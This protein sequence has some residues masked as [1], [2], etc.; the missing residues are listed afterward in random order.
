VNPYEHY[1]V[2]KPH[3]ITISYDDLKTWEKYEKLGMQ[4]FQRAAFVLVAGGLGERLG[5]EGIKVSIPK[6][7]LT[8][9][10][11]LQYYCEYIHAF[12]TKFCEGNSI[13]LVIMTSEDTHAK[14]LALLETNKYFGLRPEQV[15]ILNQEKVP[16]MVDNEGRFGVVADRLE[17]ETKPHGHGD[18]HTLLHMHGTAEKWLAEGRKWI[19]I[20]Q[21]TNPFAL[22]S[23][24]LLL[25]ISAERNFDFNSL[26][27]PRKPGEA[28]GA[29]TTLVHR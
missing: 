14:T 5:Y 11:F 22:R 17:I 2:G 29:I 8:T 23:F 15:T 4:E 26:A 1:E 3:G 27:V 24:A 10:C 7:L 6:E 19:I 25:G 18:V 20:F 9:K 21:D 12:E 28:V 13:P 16:A